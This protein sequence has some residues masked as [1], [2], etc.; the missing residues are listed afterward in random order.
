M[1]MSTQKRVCV[2]S[3]LGIVSG[4]L[5][6]RVRKVHKKRAIVKHYIWLS[7][8]IMLLDSSVHTVERIVGKRGY[9]IE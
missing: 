1:N 3:L 4:S 2:F 7:F 6:N 9:K 8:V 5:W